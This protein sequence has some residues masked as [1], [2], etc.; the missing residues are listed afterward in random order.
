VTLRHRG[1]ACRTSY[2]AGQLTRPS[3][4]HYWVKDW[5]RWSPAERVI[6]ILVLACILLIQVPL[7]F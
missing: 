5:N 6:A 3:M 2:G 7:I 4:K 1:R